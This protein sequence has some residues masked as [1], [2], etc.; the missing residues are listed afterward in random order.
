MKIEV[1]NEILI[2]FRMFVWL[3]DFSY[4]DHKISKYD[5]EIEKIYIIMIKYVNA[6]FIK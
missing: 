3:E 5:R 2:I 4:F 1:E 6:S